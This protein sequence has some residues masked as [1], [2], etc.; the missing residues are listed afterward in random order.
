MI[1][2]IMQGLCWIAGAILVVSIVIILIRENK[3][4]I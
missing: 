1:I 2:N 3:D 4:E